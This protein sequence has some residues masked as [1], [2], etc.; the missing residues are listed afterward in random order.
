MPETI[1]TLATHEV[2]RSLFPRPVTEI[3]ARAMIA[4]KVIDTT[5]AR[6]SHEA[7]IGRRPTATA[8]LA[9]ASELYEEEVEV[10]GLDP[11]PVDRQRTLDQVQA[12]LKA[13]RASPLF[14]LARP[15]TRWVLVN[16]EVGLYAQP[17]Y[18]DGRST[19][20]EMKSYRP[21]PV[22]PDVACQLRCFQLAYPGF[23]TVLVGLERRKFPVETSIV[24][25][26]PSNEPER[27]EILRAILRI[28]RVSGLPKVAAYLG[29]PAASYQVPEG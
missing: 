20:Y 8:L 16:G 15:R 14:G 10:A 9:S 24:P 17:D 19:I 3:D 1:R 23:S 29:P 22:P 25:V 7:R 13:F 28:G 5:L 4:G 6:C 18:W 21:V 27:G 11:D 12:V 2:V 26:E